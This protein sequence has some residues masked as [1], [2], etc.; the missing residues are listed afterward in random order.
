MVG[1]RDRFRCV[2][3]DYPG[4]GLSVRPDGYGYTPKEHAQIAGELVDHLQLDDMI[5]MGQDW[6]GPIS[7][8]M[9]AARADRV[10][11]IVLGNTWFWR[12]D[13]GM[14]RFF[15]KLMSTGFMQRQIV[16]K[17]LFIERMLPFSAA[18]KLS[19]EVMEHYRAVQPTPEMRVGVAQFPREILASADWLDE[20]ESQV[21][22]NL[23]SKPVLLVWG[24]KDRAFRPKF[25]ARM[26]AVFPD[27]V[28]VE[29]PKAKHF[30]QE[31][32]PEEI[33]AA[34]IDRFG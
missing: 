7:M 3:L 5:V 12:D 16:E 13:S 30:I 24:M 18:T 26:K 21:K 22:T 2:A 29:L 17:N 10:S 34:I 19:D 23:A 33:V 6:G 9:A 11:G 4:F 1:L 32:A 28:V 27:R 31:D 25:L 15:S 8:G 14:L 20:L